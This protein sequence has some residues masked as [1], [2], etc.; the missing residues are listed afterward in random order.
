MM[1]HMKKKTKRAVPIISLIIYGTLSHHDMHVFL[2]KWW[3]GPLHPIA[4]C[5]LLSL[6]ENSK[7]KTFCVILLR[8]GG[9]NLL[10]SF[11]SSLIMS[12]SI[13]V[14]SAVKGDELPGAGSCLI[15][16]GAA[17]CVWVWLTF[18]INH[19]ALNSIILLTVYLH[20]SP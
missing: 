9:D 5:Y 15:C 7:K 19:K 6:H 4:P 1:L 20:S 2:W 12:V 17:S 18:A 11:F 3:T 16:T 8:N 14:C 13:W 10:T